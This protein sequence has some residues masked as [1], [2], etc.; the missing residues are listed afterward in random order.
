MG[1]KGVYLFDW[2][3]LYLQRWSSCLQCLFVLGRLRGYA[4]GLVQLLRNC[5]CPDLMARYL[6]EQVLEDFRETGHQYLILLAANRDRA[7]RRSPPEEVEAIADQIYEHAVH[8]QIPKRWHL[9][10]LFS[11]AGYDRYGDGILSVWAAVLIQICILE[12]HWESAVLGLPPHNPYRLPGFHSDE[13]LLDTAWLQDA[14]RAWSV[15]LHAVLAAA[16]QSEVEEPSH[17]LCLKEISDDAQ[18]GPWV[19]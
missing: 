14:R 12:Q 5:P 17:D 3:V 2:T 6:L 19:H 9:D 11:H 7:R 4:V 8:E 16:E 18:P 10:V 13:D 15:E 1:C